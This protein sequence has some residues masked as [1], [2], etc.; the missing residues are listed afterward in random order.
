MKDAL[1]NQQ[2]VSIIRQQLQKKELEQ[3]LKINKLEKHRRNSI[4]NK[5]C[6]G[7]W[8]TE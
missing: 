2:K 6:L 1:V 7:I 8:K 5:K 4:P 3:L